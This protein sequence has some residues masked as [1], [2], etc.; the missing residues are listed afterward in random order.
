VVPPARRQPVVAWEQ[1][2]Q[3][4]DLVRR[5]DI[6]MSGEMPRRVVANGVTGHRILLLTGVVDDDRP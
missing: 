3:R 2:P 5:V 1:S 6:E 4:R